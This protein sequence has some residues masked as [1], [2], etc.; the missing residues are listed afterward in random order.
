MLE[1][2]VITIIHCNNAFEKPELLCPITLENVCLQCLVRLNKFVVKSVGASIWPSTSHF[3][4]FA[5]PFQVTHPL[6]TTIDLSC[7]LIVDKKLMM[8]WA[9]WGS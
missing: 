5:L 6:E 1:S 8:M 4:R 2:L 7:I 3:T 9:Y